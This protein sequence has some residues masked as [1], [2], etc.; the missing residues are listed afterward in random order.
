MIL[1]SVLE[2]S[3]LIKGEHFLKQ[4]SFRDDESELKRPDVVIKLPQKRSIIIDSKVSL[5]N[6]DKYIYA[7]NDNERNLYLDALSKDIKAHIDIL[8]SKDYSRYALGTLQYIFM[9]VP[10]EG[11]LASALNHDKGLFEYALKKNIAI[12]TPSTLMVTLRTIYI[13]WQSEKANKNSERLFDEAGKLYDKI[14]VFVDTFVKVG[15]Q[16]ETLKKSYDK[17][18][19]QLK[20]G[21]GNILTR[22]AKL[23]ELGAKTAK[24]LQD[25]K[26][27]YDS[28]DTDE[29]EV[30]VLEEDVKSIT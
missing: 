6:Y 15:N 4:E 12:V 3:G 27:E 26:I 18:L 5:T 16:I 21:S 2:S 20:Y 22:V 11:A 24:N 23:K 30:E 17:S 19:S 8:S 25:S 14:V 10:I 9:F 28:F 7:K 29:L 1:D 13:Y